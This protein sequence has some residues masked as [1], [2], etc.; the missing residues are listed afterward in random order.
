[1]RLMIRH[2][3]R[4]VRL[5][6]DREL[7]RDHWHLLYQRGPSPALSFWRFKKLEPPKDRFWADPHI[8][9]RDGKHHVFIEEFVYAEKKGRISVISLDEQGPASAARPVLDRPYHLSNPFVFSCGQDLY[10]IPE[11]MSKR[12][13]ELYRC[14]RFPDQWELKET[15]MENVRAVD[16]TPFQRDGRWWLFVNIQEEDGASSSD[17][18]FLFSAA[19]PDTKDWLPH[20]MNPIVSDVRRARPAGRLFERNGNLYRPAQDCSGQYGSR[21]VLNRITLLSGTDYEER[22][23]ETLGPDWDQSLTGFHTIDFENGLTV[24]DARRRQNRLAFF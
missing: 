9:H 11:S 23:V 6:V 24:V 20:P 4:Y 2:I 1:M 16:A 10:L 7:Y 22:P 12:T 8:H 13:V 21:I 19:R 15:L 5:R 18:L 17:E 14:V 3:G